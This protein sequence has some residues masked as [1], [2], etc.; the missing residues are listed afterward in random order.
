MV[1]LHKLIADG[2]V[3]SRRKAEELILQG[4]VSVNGVV[5]K[6]LGIKVN[7]KEDIVTVD[8]KDICADYIERVYVVFN[9][10]RGCVTTLS[11]PQGRPTV[12]D[13]LGSI[14]ERIYPVGR[15]DFYSEGLLLLTNDGDLANKIMHPKHNVSKVYEVKVFGRL[16]ERLLLKLRGGAN[17]D[18]EFLKPK[19]VDVVKFL[20]NKTWLRFELC[21]G[22]NR[23]I[24]K[25]CEVVGLTVDKLKRI[26]IGELTIDNL[27]PG[28]YYY[29]SKREL[30][31]K[32]G[33]VT[34]PKVTKKII[35]KIKPL[36]KKSSRSLSA[37][38]EEFIKFRRKHYTL[39]MENK[40]S[41]QARDQARD[42]ALAKKNIKN[43]KNVKNVKPTNINKKVKVKGGYKNHDQH[44]H[45]HKH[46]R[47]Y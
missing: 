16:D 9:K 4:R 46:K 21:E 31:K 29:I 23:E 26:S 10:P 43:V 45:K 34:T 15:L 12:M 1:R 35:K 28:K 2:G 41:D 36:R 8:E 24:R 32:L 17:V 30:L 7:P 44:K 19:K 22:K 11:D 37:D 18:G 25:L 40:K 14:K 47:K 38:S 13:Y 39:T 3:T 5:V 6:E 33:V 20:P 27:A 42:K